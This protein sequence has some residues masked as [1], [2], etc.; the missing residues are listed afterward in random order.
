MEVGSNV[1][2][3]AAAAAR[4]YMGTRGVTSVSYGFKRVNGRMTDEVAII[5][6]VEKKRPLSEL[7][8]DDVLPLAIVGVKTDVVERKAYVI[9]PP[10][11]LEDVNTGRDRPVRGGDSIGHFRITAG[12]AA[13][14]LV[15]DGRDCLMSNNHVMANQNEAQIGDPILQPG[16]YDRGRDPAD[17]VALLYA[18]TP[19]STTSRGR[20]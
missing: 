18:F 12:T 11:T 9:L 3:G 5:F 2:F 1:K 15:L 17:R 8:P 6:G 14:W 20:Q 4:V 19:I 13:C 16:P 7:H 10:V